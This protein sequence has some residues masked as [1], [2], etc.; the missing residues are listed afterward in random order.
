MFKFNFDT[1]TATN[2]HTDDQKADEAELGAPAQQVFPR[3]S[4]EQPASIALAWDAIALSDSVTILKVRV[5]HN[6]SHC[7]YLPSF[8]ALLQLRITD[9][10]ASK[11][12]KDDQVLQND[13]IPGKY[14]GTYFSSRP[15]NATFSTAR[16]PPHVSP[17]SMPPTGGFKLWEGSIDLARYLVEHIFKNCTT[18]V[19][20]IT[21]LELG[22]GHGIPGLVA[23]LAGCT[24]D[25]QDYNAEVLEVLTSPTVL[26]NWRANRGLDAPPPPV[27][28]YSGDWGSLGEVLQSDG[29]GSTHLEYDYI[30]TAETIYTLEG[31]KRLFTCIKMVRWMQRGFFLYCNAHIPYTTYH[32]STY[33]YAVLETEE[34][35]VYCE[36]KIVL[37]WCRRWCGCI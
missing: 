8:V 30:F 22:C 26:A 20:S 13:L 2:S 31:M 36:C 5:P 15:H 32:M 17:P 34:R 33:T 10:E 21:V 1:Q 14:E 11:A 25:F 19:H 23:L 29:D 27:R 6:S 3:L 37:F 35:G 4:T 7:I 28:Y 24:V 18:T 16:P 12:L 9:E